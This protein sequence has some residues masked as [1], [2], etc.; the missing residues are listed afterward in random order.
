MAPH[1]RRRGDPHGHG[2]ARGV[3]LMCLLMCTPMH[4]HPRSILLEGRHEVCQRCL[5]SSSTP[6]KWSCRWLQQ[7]GSPRFL[8]YGY[9]DPQIRV[10]HARFR[11]NTLL[12]HRNPT[13]IA[14]MAMHVARTWR[15]CVGRG[16]VR[17]PAV[18]WCLMAS[19]WGY[20]DATSR[21]GIVELVG[22]EL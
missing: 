15:V 2:R 4:N 21:W 11:W 12:V 20:V 3:Q 7:L 22:V 10:H 14:Q 19:R 9:W 1:P 8:P 18:L 13:T 16:P 17:S 5:V 6:M